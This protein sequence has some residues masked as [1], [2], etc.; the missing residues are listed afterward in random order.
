[1]CVC[2]PENDVGRSSYG[3]LQVKEAFEYAYQELICRIMPQ[4]QHLYRPNER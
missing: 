3:A 1:M 2:V 4:Y